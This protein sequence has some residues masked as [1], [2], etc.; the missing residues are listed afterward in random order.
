MVPATLSILC[1]LVAISVFATTAPTRAEPPSDPVSS[2]AKAKK[3][4]RNHIYLGHQQ[5]L[6]CDCGFKHSRTASGGTINNIDCGYRPRKS[7]TR[8]K[9][10]EWEHILPAA[11]RD[12]VYKGRGPRATKIGRRTFFTIPDLETFVAECR[13]L[14]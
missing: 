10:L 9:R 14:S 11:L 13:S 6:Y 8:G 2:F 12:M 7:K 5:T 3:L 1:S 4:A